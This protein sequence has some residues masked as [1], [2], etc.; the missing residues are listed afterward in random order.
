MRI[1]PAA[2]AFT[3]LLGLLVALPSFGIDMSPPALAATGAALGA[4]PAEV[5]LTMSAF[6]LGFSGG[7]LLYGPASDR[8][9]RKLVVAAFACALCVIDSGGCGLA[10]SSLDLLGWR[11]VQGAG[12]GASM[13][14]AMAIVRDLFQVQVERSLT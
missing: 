8:Y 2:T 4:A 6:M 9:G 13:T 1:A 7:P 3:L 10:R 5:S 14:M 12:A 11:L